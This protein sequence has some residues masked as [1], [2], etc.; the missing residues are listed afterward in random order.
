M[1]GVVI[2]Q[3]RRMAVCRR[4]VWMEHSLSFSGG[5]A[6]I[7][8]MLEK[9]RRFQVSRGQE[10]NDDNSTHIQCERALHKRERKRE[11]KRHINFK[12]HIH[13]PEPELRRIIEKR[14]FASPNS[15]VCA[16]LDNV[17]PSQTSLGAEHN[18]YRW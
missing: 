6:R 4:Y 14:L 13:K 5:N 17:F 11:K 3:W 1:L 10:W 9:K 18:M 12:F 8:S 15:A 16:L 2:V 7:S